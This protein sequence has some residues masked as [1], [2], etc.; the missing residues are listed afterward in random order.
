MMDLENTQE[1]R[2]KELVYTGWLPPDKVY[3]K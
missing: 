2:R 1:K 3:T